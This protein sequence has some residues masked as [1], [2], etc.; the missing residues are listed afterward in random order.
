MKHRDEDLP[1]WND[2]FWTLGVV[3]LIFAL[4]VLAVFMVGCC[5]TVGGQRVCAV[6]PTN[7][8]LPTTTAPP[9]TPSPTEAPTAT[10]APTP[11][12]TPTPSA[13]VTRLTL[14]N[15]FAG[16]NPDGGPG[17]ASCH[18]DR[19][20]WFA[21]PGFDVLARDV[22][23]T[24]SCARRP[25]DTNCIA[26]CNRNDSPGT[27]CGGAPA[28][29]QDHLACERVRIGCNGRTWDDPRGSVLKATG[30]I[31]CMDIDGYG[32]DCTGTPGASYMLCAR[33]YADAH[34]ADGV[35][36][37]VQGTGEHCTSGVF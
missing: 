2:A 31:E 3:C 16:C 17:R 10:A 22:N 24:I 35:P 11:T 12:M 34:T 26:S 18:G 29:D 28:C 36:I 1:G 14:V 7:A 9:P 8:P 30:G 21:M 13:W 20:F 37:P 32:F 4:A 5:V 23:C 15:G 27:P 33:P 6:A 19:T 25:G